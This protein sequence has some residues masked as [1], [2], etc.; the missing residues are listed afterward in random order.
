MKS[1]ANIYCVVGKFQKVKLSKAAIDS[2]SDFEKM[3]SKIQEYVKKLYK[4]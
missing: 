4:I 2:Q 1:V 3:F